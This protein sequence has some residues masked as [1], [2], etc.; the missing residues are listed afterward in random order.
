MI[1]E[2]VISKAIV[3]EE[4]PQQKQ[5]KQKVKSW[6]LDRG[7]SYEDLMKSYPAYTIDEKIQKFLSK[8]LPKFN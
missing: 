5:W 4:D 3:V 1:K 8:I 7:V 2:M 6:V